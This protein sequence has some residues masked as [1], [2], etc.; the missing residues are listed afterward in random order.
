MSKSSCL[1]VPACAVQ[2]PCRGAGGV[3][4]GRA[5]WWSLV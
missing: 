4:Q 2:G 1:N 3:A 5:H